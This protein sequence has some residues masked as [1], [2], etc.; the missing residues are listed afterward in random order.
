M[1]R[2]VEIDPGLET[3]KKVRYIFLAF[4]EGCRWSNFADDWNAE[5]VSEAAT[6]LCKHNKMPLQ[7]S[8]LDNC[9]EDAMQPLHVQL[10]CDGATVL[11]KFT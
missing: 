7:G 8:F 9:I 2:F 4:Q 10:P 5:F 6:K 1:R 11:G 3:Y